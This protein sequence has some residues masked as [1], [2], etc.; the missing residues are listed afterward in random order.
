MPLYIGLLAVF[1]A[2]ILSDLLF[3]WLCQ[4]KYSRTERGVGPAGLTDEL[5]HHI[6]ANIDQGLLLFDCENKLILENE[7]ARE[8]FCGMEWGG[9]P[10]IG[11]LIGLLEPGEAGELLTLGADGR[12][13]S[14]LCYPDDGERIRPMRCDYSVL[15][16]K[17][18]EVLGRLF[19]YTEL[20]AAYD[21]L[22]GFYEW[23]FYKKQEEKERGKAVIAAACDINGLTDLNS[24]FG[25]SGGD[26]AIQMLARQLRSCFP[27]GTCFVRGREAI[28]IAV[29][30]E[31][32]E[33]A[34][35]SYLER[36]EDALKKEPFLGKTICFQCS[37]KRQEPS[38]KR[39]D[40]VRAAMDA[41]R[42]RKLLDHNSR[43]SDVLYSLVRTLQECDKDTEAHVRRT[44]K[45]GGKLG[46]RLG[47][48][49][50]Q[51]SHLALLAILHDIGKIGI[52]PEI[53]NK[54]GRL[55]DAEWGVLKTHVE[56]GY[57]IAKSSAELKGIA[58]MILY[59]H[60][61]WDGKGYPDGLSK[62]SIPLLSRVI[63]VV[64]AYDA[65]VSD[66]PYRS[67]MTFEQ[68]CRELK[69]CAGTQ[70]DPAIVS[71]FLQILMEEAPV[72]L[73]LE[74]GREKKGENT[75]QWSSESQESLS[76]K[77]PHVH[78]MRYSRYIVDMEFQIIEVD[79]AFEQLTGYTRREVEERCLTQ[80]DLIFEEDRADYVNLVRE[81]AGRHSSAYIEHRI[82]RKDGRSVYVFCYGRRFYDSAAGKERTEIIISDSTATYS[83]QSII[84]IEQS[85]ASRR[86]ERWENKFRRDS[87]TGLL[88][89]EAFKN[90][91]ETRLLSG[92]MQAMMLMM[93]VDRF[94][95]YNDTY[96]HHAGD[97]FLI[98]VAQTLLTSLRKDDFA[99]R[100]G[101]DEFA[102]ML[103]FKNDTPKERMVER[104]LQICDK[105]NLTL[106]AHKQGGTS[107]SMGGAFL[108]E[109]CGTFDSL[110]EAADRALYQSKESGRGRVSF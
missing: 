28:L 108:S 22:T 55:T 5:S 3:A 92:G 61:R 77:V 38:E 80:Y 89:H 47:L 109:E 98:M 88:H 15:P 81:E 46:R 30:E 75:L 6:L 78:A 2:V 41:L 17:K 102:A 71:E 27:A 82:R 91:V 101:G 106:T 73:K 25:R 35:R 99:C 18:G 105:I 48:T 100:M 68:A 50:E 90:D 70:F 86:L 95:E 107:L 60:E 23:E 67:A 76:Q 43:H 49:E 20:S 4:K 26:R 16:G 93:D 11:D 103:F 51:Q 24:E 40:T 42:T 36:M 94:K 45:L 85:K 31:E 14:L 84:Q 64:D 58:E 87:L 33:E 63:A 13:Y 110:Y 1:I 62:E 96:G 72:Y 12:K 19:I 54:P 65:M 57:E 32:S 8:L 29:C 104:A 39:S 66:R 37:I 7:K 83:V 74:E 53:L 21:A 10:A 56:K 44:Q 59:H 9:R 69:R 97:E 52:P 34:V 79:E